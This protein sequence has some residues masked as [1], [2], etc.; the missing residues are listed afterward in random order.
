VTPRAEIEIVRR[1]YEAFNRGDLDAVVELIGPDFEWLPPEQSLT[2]GTYQGPEAVR[3]EI[4]AWTDP[5]QDFRWE[6]QE[7]IEA[8]DHILVAGRMSGRGKTSGAVVSV[9]EYHVW[10]IRD[11]RPLRM[12]M[13]HDPEQASQA[14]GLEQHEGRVHPVRD[15][16]R[17]RETSA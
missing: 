12:R 10:T 13:Y 7:I 2:A 11:G 4:T 1:G 6:I 14:A 8:G 17:D 16:A 5:F 9:I 15:A 3:A